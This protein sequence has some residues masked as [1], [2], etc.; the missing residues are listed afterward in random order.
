MASTAY[1]DVAIPPF[2]SLSHL[3]PSHPS[4]PIA[5]SYSPHQDHHEIFPEERPVVSRLVGWR[6]LRA[7]PASGHRKVSP[8]HDLQERIMDLHSPY[9]P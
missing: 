8:S 9:L 3:S 4:K 2:S 7:G 5:T 1:T 6:L